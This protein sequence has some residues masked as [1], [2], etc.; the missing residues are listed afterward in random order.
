M[1]SRA[2]LFTFL[3]NQSSTL[4]IDILTNEMPINSESNS[5]HG[6]NYIVLHNAMHVVYRNQN[7]WVISLV[8][9]QARYPI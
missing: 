1:V 4:H 5:N 3:M 2:V 6:Y 7:V 8:D 9:K